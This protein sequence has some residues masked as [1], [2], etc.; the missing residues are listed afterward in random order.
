MI[1]GLTAPAF[2]G[3]EG[4]GVSAMARGYAN[5][6]KP[7]AQLEGRPNSHASSVPSGWAL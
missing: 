5:E 7:P 1:G 2:G 3:K 6:S 4:W